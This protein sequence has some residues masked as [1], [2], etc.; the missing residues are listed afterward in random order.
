MVLL[1][2]EF[3]LEFKDK[4]SVENVVADH[5][6][7]HNFDKILKLLPFNK[8]SP[9]EQLMSAKALSWYAK[10]INNLVI[11]TFQIVGLSRTRTN[12][13]WKQGISFGI[14]FIYSS[15]IWIKLLDNAS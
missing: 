13:L 12:F 9:N 5:L 11:D 2:E 8:S 1:L 6:S 10:I 4:K 15:I 3:N 7:C 14:N